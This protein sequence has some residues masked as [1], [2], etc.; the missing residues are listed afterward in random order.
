M[1]VAGSRYHA[2][3]MFVLALTAL[4]AAALAAPAPASKPDVDPTLLAG[5]EARSIGPATMSGRVAA[6]EALVSDPDT[7]YVGAAT[8][9][10]WKSTDGALTFEPLFDEQPVAAIGAIAVFQPSPDIVWVG[11]GEGNP[12]NSVS[13]GNGIYKSLDGGRT[14]SHLGLVKTER[15]HR[16]LL[17]PSDPDVAYVAALGPLWGE[18]TERGVFKTTDG[19]RNWTQ[20]LYL[21]E[22]TGAA[23]LVMDP[24][25]PQ[26]LIAAMWDHR[27]WPWSF[28]SG[29]PGSGIH[30]TRDGGT[31]WRRLEQ[32][33]G[34][35]KGEL[36]R[37]GLAIAPSDP[38][39]VYALV[40]A[41]GKDNVV[42]R[43]EDG[44]RKWKTVA[45][46]S[47]QTRLGNRPFYYA[48]LRVDPQDPNRLYS[49][50][51]QVS[52]S[53][54]GG[55]T[56]DILVSGRQAHPDHHAMWISPRDPK[57][58]YEGNDGGV[59]VSRDRG[60]SWS[61]A[62]NLPLGQYY[63]VAVDMETPYHVYGGMQDN[64]SWRGPSAV[65][66]NGGIRNH[67][68]Q[69]VGFGDGFA[70]LPMP[71][72]PQRGYAMSQGGFLLRWDLTTGERRDIRPPAP[73]GLG[74]ADMRFNWNA[75]IAQDP[76]DPATIYYGSQFVHQSTDRGEAWTT[77]SPDL[78]S[79]NP[80]WQKQA[81]SG[82]LT[83]DVT[84]AE[85]YTTILTIAPS[86]LARGLLWVGTDDG[87]IQ[88]TRDGGASW[89]SLEGNLRGVPA[90]TWIPHIEPSKFDA[91]E[92]FVV[93]DDHRR[94]NWTPYV[95]RTRDYGKT[96]TSLS[97]PALRGYALVL[98]QDPVD[99][100]LLF[101]GTEF[102]L[103]ISLD[104]GGRWLPFTHGFPT[105]SAMAMTVHP[106]DHDLVVGTHG[107]S[108]YV[109][110][111]I[112]PLRSLTPETM[113]APLHFYPVAA[114]IQ[115]RVA[116]TGGERFPGDAE[117]R[118]ENRPD[119]ALLTY[120]LNLPGLPHPREDEERARKVAERAEARRQKAAGVVS[121]AGKPAQ[122]ATAAAEKGGEDEDKGPQVEIKV[123]DAEGKV[124]R[125]FKAPARLG[126]NRAAWD[127]R[128]DLFKEP[129]RDE[130]RFFEPSGPP[131]LPGDYRVTVKYKENE[132]T[133]TVRVLPDPRQGVAETDRRAQWEA[134]Q[135]AGALQER[136]TEAIER[137]RRTRADVETVT[138]LAR[139]A[140]EKA[141]Q[142]AEDE[143]SAMEEA[144]TPHKDLLESA[145]KLRQAV[146]AAEKTLWVPP[147]TK[148]IV[149]DRTP[150]SQIGYALRALQSSSAAPSAGQL[151]HLEAAE[152]S[153]AAVEPEIDRLYAEDVARFRDEVRASG[154]AP[155][156]E[157]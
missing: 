47:E 112:S 60:R 25:N 53:T 34:L 89:T 97:T 37:I 117:F 59:Y 141:K 72:D 75:A 124:V 62:G 147:R 1:P 48:D 24:A 94:S 81:D 67:H 118:G 133:Q 142:A 70:T 139:A 144:S 103:W 154:L 82:G 5:L 74:A 132:A 36:G 121:E 14:W 54:D 26:K 120:S 21:D 38:R 126:V 50:W 32:E 127:L 99:R 65:W 57:L 96:W 63:H 107:R 100:E 40:E 87:R 18:G 78:T 98:E 6:I 86:A 56:F 109:V 46:S 140:Q 93:L 64:G 90:H 125:T 28:R 76:F 41:E 49:L 131:V 135:R 84:G 143:G 116:Q 66:E 77:I 30:V 17:H 102:G 157:E 68:W 42:L 148:G 2:L 44:G 128:A 19:G 12:R 61:F 3:S 115:H 4:A 101:L 152:R 114:A 80:E 149:Y 88:L 136:A 27:R 39:V 155:L 58:L 119:G 110:D 45:K 138:K 20:V 52:V 35:P 91:G 151:A 16:I 134:L 85:N 23:D 145:K 33:D 146:E 156:A 79:D 9:G 43:S 92:A 13:V 108:A 105:V 11:T 83:P 22:R 31:T 15:I 153:L 7:L 104:G 10:L 51:S 71:D 113:A 111:D 69:E 123:E 130:P 106:R 150:W 137:L 95:Y 122:A 129:K 8:G 73:S 55:R 29:G